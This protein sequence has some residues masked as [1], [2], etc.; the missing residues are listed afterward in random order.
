LVIAIAFISTYF[1]F[2]LWVVVS[3][4]LIAYLLNK[5]MLVVL[6]K[7]IAKEKEMAEKRELEET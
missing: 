7:L 5:N 6:D 2:F 1:Y 4:S 3:I